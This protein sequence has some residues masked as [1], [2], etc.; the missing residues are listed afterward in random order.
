MEVLDPGTR[1]SILNWELL[2]NSELGSFDYLFYIYNEVCVD[3]WFWKLLIPKLG[4][5]L[6]RVV[7]Y[8]FE[9]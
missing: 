5:N 1:V 7:E 4:L 2:G 6:E 3:S 8:C 9:T